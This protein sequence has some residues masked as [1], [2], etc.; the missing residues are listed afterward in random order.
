MSCI[1]SSRTRSSLP[2]W[3]IALRPT[4]AT[5][6]KWS[7][8][9]FAT[10]DYMAAF[11]TPD[12]EGVYHLQPIMPPSEQGITRD[13]VFDLAYWRWGL[14]QAQRVARADGPGS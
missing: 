14:D 2:S 11:P 4:R 10:A 8:I 7:E 13:T 5:L 12:A 1:G 9:V 3:N 6:E